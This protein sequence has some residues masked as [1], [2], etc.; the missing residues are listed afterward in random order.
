M[1]LKLLFTTTL[2][3]YLAF[4]ANLVDVCELALENNT[5]YLNSLSANESA[6][7]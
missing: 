4:A 1:K 2:I 6:L 7:N 3:P 5:K